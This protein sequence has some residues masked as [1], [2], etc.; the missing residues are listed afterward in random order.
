MNPMSTVPFL[1]TNEINDNSEDCKTHTSLSVSSIFNE[2]QSL[3][4]VATSIV[5]KSI[6]NLCTITNVQIFKI[7]VLLNVQ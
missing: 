2:K 5:F 1:G 3:T 7:Y 6:I 4:L